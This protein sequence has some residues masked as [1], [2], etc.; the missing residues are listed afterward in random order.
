MEQEWLNQ[1]NTLFMCTST[2]PEYDDKFP[3][4]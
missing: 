1:K 3:F 2:I 4:G